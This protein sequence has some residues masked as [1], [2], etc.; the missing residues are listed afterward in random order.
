MKKNV[1]IAGGVLVFL[2]VI[3]EVGLRVFLGLGSPPLVYANAKFGYAFKPNQSLK[4]FGHSIFYNEQGLRS[5]A[6]RPIAGTAYR[7]LCV[8]GSVTNG[9]ALMDQADTYS[10]QLE[11]ILGAK[12]VQVQVLNASAV[13]WT[14]ANEYA[15]LQD[16]GIFDARV[17]VLEAGTRELY[18]ESETGSAVGED[19][20][21]PDHNPLLALI[22]VVDRYILP[23]VLRR[24][25]MAEAQRGWTDRAITLPNYQRGLST[26]KAMVDLVSR[27]GAKPIILM[28]P[29]KD[30]AVPGRYR[31]E[32][33]NDLSD[34]AASGNGKLIDLMPAWHTE[35]SQGR[36]PFRDLINP[37]PEG[38]RIIAN[39]LAAVAQ[40]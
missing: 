17:I 7:V 35:L 9:G 19:P 31:A 33:Q 15:F 37:N 20:N 36:E 40:P 34:L 16:K 25:G 2:L 12:G 27:T 29:D 18:P 3:A 30:E 4:R 13:G 8:G 10:Y 1:I 5:E 39:A 32:F 38:N 21:L 14:L 24:L 28:V 6:L 22:E 26:L 23:R 11:R